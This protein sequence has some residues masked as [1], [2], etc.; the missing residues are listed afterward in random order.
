MTAH[1]AFPAIVALWFA[2]LLGIGSVVVPPE[3]LSVLVDA[4]GIPRIIHAAA[5]PL[6]FTARMLLALLMAGVGVVIGLVLGIR[7]AH[8]A[9]VPAVRRTDPTRAR[10]EKPKRSHANDPVDRDPEPAHGSDDERPVRKR[11][12][13]RASEAFADIEPLT[14]APPVDAVVAA[15]AP[16][17]NYFA[18][19]GAPRP[20]PDPADA[21]LASVPAEAADTTLPPPGPFG[22]P[23]RGHGAEPAERHPFA[24]AVAE[25][26]LP[27]ETATE[28]LA[29]WP[30]VAAGRSA[31]AEI[32]RADVAELGTVQLV[33]RLAL[34]MAGRACS[35]QTATVAPGEAPAP[36]AGSAHHLPVDAVQLD[37]DRPVADPWQPLGRGPVDAH[38]GPTPRDE[39]NPSHPGDHGVPVARPAILS[40]VAHV[41]D[42]EDEEDEE[43]GIAPPR[44][45]SAGP[46]PELLL[47]EAVPNE[48]E[49]KPFGKPVEQSSPHTSDS[50]EQQDIRYPSLLDIQPA[51]R[52][53]IQIGATE[54]VAPLREVEPVV[55]FPGSSPRGDAPFAP[56][57]ASTLQSRR[58]LAFTGP[59]NGAMG[60]PVTPPDLPSD[61]ADAEEADRA[62]R[63]ALATLQRMS[64]S[65]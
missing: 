33:E 43:D 17:P 40:P 21:H 39:P 27:V 7:I 34:A 28:P 59:A 30:D 56:P 2:A 29:C 47:E 11:G 5:P 10:R 24:A 19:L 35:P 18:V 61:P 58:N 1:R 42:D 3:K 65:R 12:P 15:E 4:L 53:P 52:A 64:G 26:A 63:A 23:E 60:V 14:D 41:W 38:S 44:F 37:L 9:Q 49:T 57:P 36:Q 51:V 6:G 16:P 22:L 55:V 13:L 32:A 50:D 46:V 62:L 8:R 31:I 25:R 45:L 20:E 54:A 48:D